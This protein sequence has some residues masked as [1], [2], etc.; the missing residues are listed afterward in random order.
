MNKVFPQALAMEVLCVRLHG[1]TLEDLKALIKDWWP[2]DINMEEDAQKN[3]G[4]K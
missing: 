3:M 1:L 2:L 4:K